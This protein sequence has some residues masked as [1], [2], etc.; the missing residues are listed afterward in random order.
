M[1]YAGETMTSSPA[2]TGNIRRAVAGDLQ[3]LGKL[4]AE[5]VR[6]HHDIDPDRFFLPAGVEEGYR[7]WLGTEIE[8]AEAIVLVAEIAGEVVGYLYGRLE[9]RDFNMLLAEHAALHDVLVIE[10]ARRSGAAEAL[11]REFARVAAE[12]GVPRV[13]LHTATSNTRAQ[14]LFRKIGFRDTMLEMTLETPT[15]KTATDA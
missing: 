13:V 14:A 5:L 3:Q 8:N 15:K 1:R 10:R 2:F 6:F 12:R 7:R 11:I 4:A 9:K